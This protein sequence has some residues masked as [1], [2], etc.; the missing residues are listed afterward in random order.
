MAIPNASISKSIALAPDGLRRTAYPDGSLPGAAVEAINGAGFGAGPTVALFFSAS[1]IAGELVSTGDPEIGT[2]AATS[3]KAFGAVT[4]ATRYH[5]KNGKTWYTGRDPLNVAAEASMLTG[6][7]FTNPSPSAKIRVAY[8][9]AAADG[10]KVPGAA[11]VGGKPGDANASVWKMSWLDYGDGYS[12]TEPDVCIPTCLGGNWVTIAGNDVTPRFD[13]DGVDGRVNLSHSAMDF[14]GAAENLISYV[15]GDK[16]SSPGARD[17][18]LSWV[19]ATVGSNPSWA[20]ERKVQAN[21]FAGTGGFSAEVW[22]DFCLPGWHG[23]TSQ[24]NTWT[25]AN[26][27]PLFRDLYIAVGDNCEA[28]IVLSN[29]ATLSASSDFAI[30]PPVSWSDT[31]VTFVRRSYDP[32]YRHLILANGTVRENV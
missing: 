18:T 9:V 30:I 32:L 3:P 25:F 10:Y 17:G 5:S 14:S 27:L 4:G 23:N 8:K 13:D 6:V 28:C 20:Y 31:K 24:G 16:E 26:T 1:G 7:R 21:P 29:A 22:K 19:Q 11:A 2:L 15:S 12:T